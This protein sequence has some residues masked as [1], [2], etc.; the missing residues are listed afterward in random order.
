MKELTQL[1]S[2]ITWHTAGE[3][4][5]QTAV[6][7]LAL[8]RSSAPSPHDATVYEPSLC[9]TAQ[10]AKEVLLGN[11]IYR[12]DPTQSLLASVGLP[13]A[14]RVTSAKRVRLIASCPVNDPRPTNGRPNHPASRRYVGH[15]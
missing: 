10:G 15:Y 9:V 14:S 8:Y 2:A 12:Y 4:L 11:E 7:G 13:A 6:T 3:G 5:F 1:A